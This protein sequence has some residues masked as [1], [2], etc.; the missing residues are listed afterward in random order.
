MPTPNITELSLRSAVNSK[1]CSRN[2][3]DG[4]SGNAD[5][6]KSAAISQIEKQTSP[7]GG[8]SALTSQISSQSAII[9]AAVV[10]IAVAYTAVS[11][12]MA[13]AKN[14][15]LI[16]DRERSAGIATMMI[17]NNQE[18]TNLSSEEKFIKGF[19]ELVERSS[20]SS[21]LG[22]HKASLSTDT[23]GVFYSVLPF[24]QMSS[25]I[26]Q[27]VGSSKKLDQQRTRIGLFLKS[28]LPAAISNID[29]SFQNDWQVKIFFQRL[30][31]SKNYLNNRRAPRFVMMCLAN[32][33]WNLQHPV[34]PGEGFALTNAECIA[35]CSEAEEFL[36]T[37]LNESSP[38]YPENINSKENN[39]I[40]FLRKIEIYI[41]ALHKSYIEAQLHDLN[42]NDITNS[43]HRALRIMDVSLWKLIYKKFDPISRKE[44]ADGEAA[45]K[46]ADTISYL[47]LLLEHN[48]RLIE[49]LTPVPS[50]VPADSM[51]N[52][53]P[54]TIVDVIILF[55]HLS[56]KD[57]YKYLEKIE[58]NG[59]SSSLEFAHTLKELDKKFIK[60]IR[61]L[62]KKE[63][64][65]KK[66][67]SNI[68][69][70]EIG[71]LTAKRLVPLITLVMEDYRVEGDTNETKSKAFASMANLSETTDFTYSGNMQIR[72][73]NQSAERGDGYYE[74]KLSFFIGGAKELDDLPLYQYKMTGMTKLLDSV[75]EIVKTYRSF[76]LQESFQK[77]L[78]K[79]INNVMEGYANLSKQIEKADLAFSVDTPISR[80]LKAI[81]GPM[82]SNLGV[83]SASFI[84]AMR[85][86]EK[87]V[88]APDFTERE[89][90]ALAEKL[91]VVAKK[92]REVF[93]DDD[94]QL[95]SAIL[96]LGD[97]P[98]SRTSPQHATSAL[99]NPTSL[100]YSDYADASMSVLSPP[101]RK[102]RVRRA[103]R[104]QVS[105]LGAQPGAL[106]RRSSD[107]S[108]ALSYSAAVNIG[109][110]GVGTQRL[111]SPL[112]T[113]PSG[114][115]L[116]GKEG[117]AASAPGSS[118][119]RFLKRMTKEVGSHIAESPQIS[120]PDM[121]ERSGTQN[122][123][124]YDKE[125]M[126]LALIFL[127][128]RCNAALSYQSKFGRKGLLLRELK[129]MISA[130]SSFGDEQVKHILMEL[131][132]VTASY[133][134]NF[135][136]FHAAYGETRSSYALIAAIKERQINKS[137]PIAKLLF[138]KEKFD[139]SKARDGVILR[140][141]NKLCKSNHWHQSCE[142]LQLHWPKSPSSM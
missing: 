110:G 136:F 17:P 39:L 126:S 137:I 96:K 63:L 61:A 50:V 90:L 140:Q 123:S 31:W 38:Y 139:V 128:D 64:G 75:A 101:S 103:N 14:Q 80:D 15:R 16:F 74:W 26:E 21:Y 5:A 32:L 69:D 49:N 124:P 142:K 106:I 81:I 92:Y 130:T 55:C 133:Q 115:F 94:D 10:G 88:S 52:Y 111:K 107:S 73:I 113:H 41:K 114:V 97:S 67:Y 86:F 66:S 132:R 99:A 109:H 125:N 141:I 71:T 127:V 121:E 27:P 89:R 82:M 43:A 33:L 51:I 78:V 42:I 100:D 134:V 8:L 13:N 105:L 62:S 37:L 48:P 57:R 25:A 138:G 12:I 117:A 47:N 35:L 108:D 102:M 72:S 129:D 84:A 59:T 4:A 70:E 95:T 1:V 18:E 20:F 22:I 7:N 46:L 119:V 28:A 2:L 98:I 118:S 34:V 45:E 68:K 85:N 29:V 120:T 116:L 6:I 56:Y 54:V 3:T 131:I 9:E 11:Q 40:G 77:F 19:I 104:A 122:L 36:N 76:L 79:L 30:Y 135:G 24:F 91:N 44:V 83:T 53:P 23:T 65:V 93:S 60:P 58:S 112:L 87:I